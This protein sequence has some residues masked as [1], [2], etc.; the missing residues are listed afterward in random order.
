VKGLVFVLAALAV[1]LVRRRP[2]L[3]AL[4]VALAFGLSSL[5]SS[6][7]K[8]VV[9]RQRP[10]GETVIDLPSSASFPSGHATTAFAAAVALSMLVPRMAWWALPLAALISYSRVYLGVHYW[11]DVLAGAALGTAVAIGVVRALRRPL[12]PPRSPLP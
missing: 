4:T 11:S 3:F 1:D 6:T 8:V 7:L 10:G 5:C 2:P 12:E 9:D